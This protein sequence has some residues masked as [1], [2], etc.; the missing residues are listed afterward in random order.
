MYGCESDINSPS[1][2]HDPISFSNPKV[3]QISCY[4][5]YK[6]TCHLGNSSYFYTGDTLI[7]KVIE[8]NSNLKFMEYFTPKSPSFLNGTIEAVTYP[9]HVNQE[10]LLIPERQQSDLFFFYGNDTIWTKPDHDVILEQNGCFFY[11]DSNLFIGEEIGLA[12]EIKFGNIEQWNKTVVSCVPTIL[13]M[14]AYLVYDNGDL[15]VSHTIT[16]TTTQ[17][18]IKG[19]ELINN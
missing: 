5:E 2:V 14:D 19:W 16:S 1:V 6:A 15:N 17:E 3:N 4:V 18:N 8:E 13:A 11:H 12:E 10:Y 9:V 7:V